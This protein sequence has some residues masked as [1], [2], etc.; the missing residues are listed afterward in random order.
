M[1]TTDVVVVGGGF[2]GVTA[3]RELAHLGYDVVLLEAKD[4]LGGRT[5]S[6]QWHGETVEL[7][8]TWIHYLQACVWSELVR[9]GATVRSFGKSDVTLFNGGS[10]PTPLTDDERRDTTNAWEAYLS[11]AGDALETPFSV[12]SANG[13]VTAIDGQT[14]AERLDD[15][16]LK[17]DVRERLSAGL[18]SW[19]NGSIERAGAIFPHR[20]YAMSGF[21]VPALEATTTDLILADGTGNLISA[22]A[23]Q[24]NFAVRFDTVVTAVHRDDN[25]VRIHTTD[26]QT[27]QARAAVIALPLNVLGD[28]EF[29]PALPDRQAA[30]VATRQTSTGCKVLIKAHGS[31]QRVDA[32]AS[33]QAFAHVL[34]DRH[35]DDGSQLLIA[36]GPD[37]T[38]MASAELADVQRYLDAMVPGLTVD[39]FLWHD[40]TTDTCAQGTWAVHQPGWV[41]EYVTAFDDPAGTVSFAGSDIAHG[42]IGHIDGAIETGMRAARQINKILQSSPHEHTEEAR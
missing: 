33:G 21:S 5:H 15:L 31:D 18:T 10:G 24:A 20:L 37:A 14:M 26:G 30:A 13:V 28:I 35:F 19:A 25:V 22:M 36:F 9:A 29:E 23:G 11:G 3:A 40:W 7:G 16:D 34:T 27:V 39:D 42:W 41:T 8:G 12:D 38:K 2:A 6:T 17:P 4:R 32:S 1:N